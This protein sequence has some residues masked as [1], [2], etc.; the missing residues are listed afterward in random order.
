MM[1]NTVALAAIG[2]AGTMGAAVIYLAKY[3]AR[4]L[5][6]GMKAHTQAAEQATEASK[7][8]ADTVEK[9]GEEARL[10][11][12]NSRELLVFMRSLNGKFKDVAQQ[13]IQ[14]Q[15]VEHQTVMESDN[16]RGQ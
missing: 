1:E 6:T 3:F 2:L 8:L 11:S 4:E 14:E 16:N 12:E 9:V 7:K 10:S 5:M 13:K 15:T